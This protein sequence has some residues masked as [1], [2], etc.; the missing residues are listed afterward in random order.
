MS[1]VGGVQKLHYVSEDLLNKLK[2]A[3]NTKQDFEEF[4]Q[5]EENAFSGEMKTVK[6]DIAESIEHLVVE[7]KEYKRIDRVKDALDVVDMGID[8]YHEAKEKFKGYEKSESQ[9]DDAGGVENDDE[10]D[11]MDESENNFDGKFK[12]RRIDAKL[13]ETQK[14]Q[15]NKIIKTVCEEAEG[16]VFR[17]MDVS[18]GNVHERTRSISVNY[19]DKYFNS[20]LSALQ[21]IKIDLEHQRITCKG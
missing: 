16:L 5:A 6:A 10:Y 12:M 8:Y 3:I 18:I 13:D 1:V 9:A 11:E 19:V 14:N 17:K 7:T 20:V 21:D 2:E 15:L 4:V